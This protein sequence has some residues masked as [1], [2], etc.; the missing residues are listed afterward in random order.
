M[1]LAAG[2]FAGHEPEIR[3][4]GARRLKPAK[5][6]QLR[7]YQDRGQRVDPAKTA[8]PRHWLSIR[9]GL[10]NLHQV[11]IQLDEPRLD[12]IDGQQIVRP[13]RAPRPASKRVPRCRPVSSC[14][15]GQPAAQ[16]QLAQPMPTAADPHG[17]RRV[18]D[19]DPGPLLLL[20]WA[21][22]LLSATR[23]ATT[24]QLA[25]ITTIRLHAVARFARHQGRRDHLA[26]HARRRHPPLQRIAARA[27]LVTRMHRPRR[28]SLE[29]SHQPPNRISFGTVQVT[30]AAC[31]PSSIAMKRSFLCASI[32]TYVVTCFT[33]GSYRLRLWRREALT[34]DFGGRHLVECDS[35]TTLR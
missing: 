22:G 29:L 31:V 21:A 6:V 9:I 14:D 2:V 19:T 26:T 24:R 1:L 3:H 34:R 17:H 4:Q 10:R 28:L 5:V 35:T 23:R 13:P 20:A 25:G 30:G 27:G 33:T 15:R 16:E 12:L 11:G 8:Q 7:Q 18:R 32:P